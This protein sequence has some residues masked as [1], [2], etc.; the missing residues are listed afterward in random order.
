MLFYIWFMLSE[1]LLIYLDN[2]YKLLLNN[3]IYGLDYNWLLFI[4]IFY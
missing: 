3:I 4:L 1:M 2:Y